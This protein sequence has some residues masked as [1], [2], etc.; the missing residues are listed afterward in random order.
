MLSTVYVN[1]KVVRLQAAHAIGKG[2][3]A[4]VYQVGTKAI[5]VYKTPD[6]LDFTGL[7]IEQRGA[8]ERIAI[9]QRKL[10]AF[11]KNMPPRVVVPQELAYDR[12]GGK[13]VGYMMRMLAQAEL[14]IRYSDRSFRQGMAN[15][16]IRAIFQD[17]HQTVRGI[18]ATGTVIGDFN[19]L[20]ALVTGT[21]VYLIDA[22]S[23]QFAGFPCLVFTALFVDPLLCDPKATSPMLVRR[24]TPQSD[25]Y[26]FTVMLM[27][28]LLFVDPYG[29]VYPQKYGIKHA[30][31][32]L[33]RITVFDPEVR[34]PKPAI[35]YHVLPDDLLQHF[36]QVFE[37]DQ[38]GEFPLRLLE[39][40]RWTTCL[41]CGTE[42]ARGVC[43]QCAT[44]APAAVKEVTTIRGTVV[45]TR[46]F[47]TRG[48]I[49]FAT[50]QGGMIKWLAHDA[51]QFTREDGTVV[52]EGGLLPTIR[53]RI[54]GQATLLAQGNQLVTISREGQARQVID[55]YGT[56]PMFDA[57]ER[58]R[59][60]LA[61]GQLMHDAPI[62]PRLVG[63]VLPNQTLFWVGPTFG[64]GFYRAGNLSVAFVFDADRPGL[65]D[66][67]ALPP[68][69]GQVIDSTCVFTEQY[70]WFFVATRV[71]GQ[72]E[73]H[74]YLLSRL[75]QVI[76]SAQAQDGD[77]SWLANIRGKAAAG[78]FLFAPT[79]EGVVRLQAENTMLRV[80]REFPDTEPYV[81][82]TSNL[83]VGRD[84]LYVVTRKEVYR[85][86]IS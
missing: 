27:R 18:H 55:T 50:V 31:R 73:N 38:R 30:Q 2:G 80:T 63:T 64:F 46:I 4:D 35:P 14:L 86:R 54:A 82:A 51:G 68:I 39:N 58:A 1:G 75:G 36:Q 11:P 21:E 45:A 20:N 59:Y 62:A 13:I 61:N 34:Y 16:Q 40:L 83:F 5:K 23:F 28:N 70:C 3:E 65:N 69:R 71:G 12:V 24:H 78:N 32:P 37:K 26:A 76:A 67:V 44:A 9:H 84:G 42:H 79:D 52:A 57:N 47:Q 66:S 25:W 74:C 6:H 33:K 48:H 19:D 22:D 7:P 60:W 17:L 8:K 49:V 77:G 10:P 29:G 15:D 41:Q 81:T 72:S 43:P 56:T 53:Y 85:L